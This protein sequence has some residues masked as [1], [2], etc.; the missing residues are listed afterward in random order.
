MSTDASQSAGETSGAQNS[1]VE[2]STNA[3]TAPRSTDAD[4]AGSSAVPLEW[5]PNLLQSVINSDT[6]KRIVVILGSEESFD[7]HLTLLTRKGEHA[8]SLFDDDYMRTRLEASAAGADWT[9]RKQDKRGQYYTMKREGRVFMGWSHLVHCFV[10]V[11]P[12]TLQQF[13]GQISQMMTEL[14]KS[15]TPNTLHQ[16]WASD[17]RNYKATV[18]ARAEDRR[19]NQKDHR[20]GSPQTSNRQREDD[21]ALDRHIRERPHRHK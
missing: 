4:Q 14:N 12:N 10:P 9:T 15:K 7:D 17:H 8:M 13:M 21:N 6:R 1:A 19:L 2:R 5:G 18:G 20:N 11:V 3:A 16:S